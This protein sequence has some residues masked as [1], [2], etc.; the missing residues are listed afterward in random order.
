MINIDDFNR[1]HK[2]NNHDDDKIEL[3]EQVIRSV[4]MYFLHANN[5]EKKTIFWKMF[6]NLLKIKKQLLSHNVKIED[7]LDFFI[8]VLNYEDEMYSFFFHKIHSFVL[9]AVLK[10][11]K[12]YFCFKIHDDEEILMSTSDI[13]QMEK[14]LKG[15]IKYM[16]YENVTFSELPVKKVVNQ[17]Y[18]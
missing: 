1:H 12:Y 10:D 17:Y 4:N 2:I 14:C 5:Y 6:T 15:F 9:F 18:N 13:Y 11:N 8:P 7:V 16:E 3:D